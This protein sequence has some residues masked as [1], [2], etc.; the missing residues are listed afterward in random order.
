MSEKEFI[1]VLNKIFHDT[2]IYQNETSNENCG[3]CSV[4]LEEDE[5]DVDD[6]AVVA[7]VDDGLEVV[8]DDPAGRV[9]YFTLRFHGFTP[10]FG[11][12]ARFIKE[13]K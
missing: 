3:Q 9:K 12:Q 10:V 6:F 11:I 7:V 1:S 8:E 13:S 2:A 4:P 5:A